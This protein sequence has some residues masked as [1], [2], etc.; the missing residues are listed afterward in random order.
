M[1]ISRELTKLYTMKK[2]L[3]E[4][5]AVFQEH[6]D[7]QE[8]ELM[9]SPSV[10]TEICTSEVDDLTTDG[11]RKAML[12]QVLNEEKKNPDVEPTLDN[13]EG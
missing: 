6:Q 11:Y 2:Q 7:A 4:I 1:N 13:I 12:F 5:I 9:A 3:N 8:R 10:N